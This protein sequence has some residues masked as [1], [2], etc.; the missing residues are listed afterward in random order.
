VGFDQPLQY[1]IRR[2]PDGIQEVVRLQVF[3][4]LGPS[5]PGVAPELLA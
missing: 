5:K 3:V 1:G 4:E 2:E